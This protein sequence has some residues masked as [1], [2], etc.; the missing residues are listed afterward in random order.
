[1]LSQAEH[2][3]LASSILLTPSDTLIERV[4]DE[5][6]VQLKALKR[7]EIA[8]RS[9]GRYGAIIR[10]KSLDVAIDIANRI[11][12][13]HLEIMTSEPAGVVT[14][15]KNAGAAF[16]GQWTPEPLGDYSAGPNHTLPTGGTARFSSPLGVYDF[17]KRT[18]LLQFS[19]KGFMELA[20][21]VE[22]LADAEGLEAHAN[23]I[24][25]RKARIKAGDKERTGSRGCP[26]RRT[27]C[28]KR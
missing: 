5:L 21:V 22:S 12:P 19:M 13:E 27:V 28:K 23:T 4:N 9:L 14:G 3:E 16:L 8:K 6:R 2:D 10:T 17:I 26:E 20:D 15:I 25:V 24:R 1:M 11:A 18:S 7:R